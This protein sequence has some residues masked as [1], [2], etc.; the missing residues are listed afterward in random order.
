MKAFWIQIKRVHWDK[1]KSFLRE[2][3]NSRNIF[4]MAFLL[5]RFFYMWDFPAIKW[6][7]RFFEFQF[8]GFIDSYTDESRKLIMNKI[9]R[10]K[11]LKP[12]QDAKISIFSTDDFT[13]I[14]KQSNLLLRFSSEL[15]ECDISWIRQLC[16]GGFMRC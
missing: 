5:P 4:L 7:L 2:F 6:Q 12:L 11:S 16:L 10:W 13:L 8:N 9:G 1:K 14:T 15:C 3:E